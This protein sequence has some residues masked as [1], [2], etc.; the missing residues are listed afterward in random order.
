MPKTN[1]FNI[2]DLMERGIRL[3]GNSQERVHKHWHK[4]LEM[5]EKGEINP[6]KMV[7]RRA[8]LEELDKVYHKFAKMEDDMQKVF[9]QTRLS[10]APAPGTPVLTT[11]KS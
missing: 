3:I 8:A 1:H 9:A 2:G 6:L 10:F 4:L 11:F 5:I 7:F